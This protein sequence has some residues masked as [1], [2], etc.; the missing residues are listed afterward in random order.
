MNTGGNVTTAT[1]IGLEEIKECLRNALPEAGKIDLSATTLLEEIP[2][3]DSMAAVTLQMSL[4]DAF[5]TEIPEDLL[6]GETSLKEL[7]EF[8]EG[9]SPQ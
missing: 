4:Q 6:T 2:D 5:G 9:R 1:Q 3:W 7:I 8:L